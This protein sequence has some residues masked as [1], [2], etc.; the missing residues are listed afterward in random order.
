MQGLELAGQNL[1][2]TTP[3]FRKEFLFRCILL[4]AVARFPEVKNFKMRYFYRAQLVK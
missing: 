4:T 2:L 1:S 3:F